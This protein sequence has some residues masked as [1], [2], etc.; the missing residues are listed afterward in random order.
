MLPGLRS[1]SATLS[2]SGGKALLERRKTEHAIA[3]R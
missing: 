3:L 2:I 1:V